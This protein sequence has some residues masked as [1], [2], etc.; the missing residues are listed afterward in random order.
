M[1]ENTC[2]KLAAAHLLYKRSKL[3][4]YDL[5][6]VLHKYIGGRRGQLGKQKELH[7]Y[8]GGRARQP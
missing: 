6:K 7:K 1:H 5:D 3:R 8:S 2:A 4:H